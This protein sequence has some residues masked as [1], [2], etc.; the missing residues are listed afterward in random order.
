MACGF[1]Q[2]SPFNPFTHFIPLSFPTTDP[3]FFIPGFLRITC[4]EKV[5]I[6]KFTF[7]FDSLYGLTYRELLGILWNLDSGLLLPCLKRFPILYK[8]L[9]RNNTFC[10]LYDSLNVAYRRFSE[11]KYR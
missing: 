2:R 3:A 4:V 9:N 7:L 11:Q 10:I 5:P 1:N 6:H 8:V